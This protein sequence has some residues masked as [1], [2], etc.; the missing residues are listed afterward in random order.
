MKRYK[1][2]TELFA[3]LLAA[4]L[5]SAGLMLP[6][7]LIEGQRESIFNN[8]QMIRMQENEPISIS[9]GAPVVD[10]T[11]SEL[12]R[13]LSTGSGT[14]IVREP[15]QNELSMDA[16]FSMA[17]KEMQK[18]MDTGMILDLHTPQYQLTSATLIANSGSDVAIWEM[19]FAYNN[20]G[21]NKEEGVLMI[22][23]GTGKIYWLTLF[24]LQ[25]DSISNRDRA[26]LFAQYHEIDT[27]K[28]DYEYTDNK[29]QGFLKIG[30][31][32]I[33]VESS[34]FSEN[35][36]QMTIGISIAD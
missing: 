25:S 33:Q 16:A 30:S 34:S 29:D 23:A 18:L 14:S 9:E 8:T 15:N 19:K 35:R 11:Q 5:I 13:R 24:Y 6:K 26:L 32:M 10:V 3:Y 22:D 31:L 7:I 2:I 28:Q 36:F 21:I 17:K 27:D 1:R 12:I 4:A 20:E